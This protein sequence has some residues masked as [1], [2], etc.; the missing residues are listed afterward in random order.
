M[1]DVLH[2]SLCVLCYCYDVSAPERSVVIGG[3]RAYL[4]WCVCVYDA[5]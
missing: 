1:L 3:N 2:Y 4:G 5:L